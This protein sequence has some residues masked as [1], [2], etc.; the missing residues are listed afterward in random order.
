MRDRRYTTLRMPGLHGLLLASLA[1]MRA[2]ASADVTLSF[3][4]YPPDIPIPAGADSITIPGRNDSGRAF[5]DFHITLPW[6]CGVFIHRVDLRG[7]GEAPG[8]GDWDVDDNANHRSQETSD[9]DE[10]D[11]VLDRPSDT[12]WVDCRGAGGEEGG[13]EGAGRPVPPGS[14]FDI[15]ITL[16]SRL[17]EDCSLRVWP[18]D[19][20]GSA[21]VGLRG[22]R[23]ERGPR[24]V[25]IRSTR[26]TGSS[27]SLRAR[28]ATDTRILGL[29]AQ[30]ASRTAIESWEERNP[31]TGAALHGQTVSS[32]LDER[33]L[34]EFVRAVEAGELLETKL[35]IRAPSPDHG[36][37]YLVV[38][39]VLDVSFRR[40]HVL[41]GADVGLSDAISV[42]RFLFLGGDSPSC[43]ASADADDS[44]R[45]DLADAVYLLGYLYLGT[46]AP[47]PPPFGRCGPDP[48]PGALDCAG[49]EDL[50]A[51]RRRR[52]TEDIG[53][54]DTIP[55]I[56]ED[57]ESRLYTYSATAGDR[58]R[59]RMSAS[60]A[61]VDDALELL[62]PTGAV[63]DRGARVDGSLVLQRTIERSEPLTIR[64]SGTP[65]GGEPVAFGVNL[66]RENEP[67]RATPIGWGETVR[68][69][70]DAPAQFDA[71]SFAAEAGDVVR[72]RMVD[73]SGS[74]FFRPQIEILDGAGAE[75]TEPLW[76]DF[77][78]EV[79]V[80]IDRPGTCFLL[81]SSH[82]GS[83]IGSYALTIERLN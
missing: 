77:L 62:D 20:S 45:V 60:A 70:I 35:E 16:S 31:E 67:P 53:Y 58:V 44:D 55:G 21:I 81:A 15:R 49:Y 10:T 80:T 12:V 56:L 37:L 76:D 34:V 7:V 50:T 18:S 64:A 82:G 17:T 23:L 28:N 52:A 43:M 61:L 22:L 29:Y 41:G 72:V 68:G 79:D 75:L 5:C 39:P 71:Y 1:L 2:P 24:S 40:G 73:T 54:G 26:H 14:A 65:A 11:N 27:I 83:G 25:A 3:D 66:L 48:T 63:V 36:P 47:P 69:G 4:P 78:A 13:E 30:F 19:E 6:E 51:C 59:I 42:L 46:P 33:V 9:A 8:F 32:E 57:A 74:V 38:E